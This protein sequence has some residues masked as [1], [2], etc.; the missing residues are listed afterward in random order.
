MARSIQDYNG[1]KNPIDTSYPVGDIKDDSG[2]GDGTELDRTSNADIQQFF[3]KIMRIGNV[4]Y[5]HFPEN[6]YTGFQFIDALRKSCRPYKSYVMIAGGQ[7]G[8]SDPSVGTEVE[9]QIGV[10]IWTRQGIGDYIGSLTGAFPITKTFPLIS[11]RSG[12]TTGVAEI[13]RAS[14]NAIGIRT[15]DYTGAAAD[16][17][18]GIFDVKIMVYY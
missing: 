10:I 13:Y 8:T 7:S 4:S 17:V 3:A 16:D 6:E 1:Q 14:A 12:S 11:W 5:N 15:R 2:A 18:L 9:N